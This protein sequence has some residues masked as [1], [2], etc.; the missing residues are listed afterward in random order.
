MT[1]DLI[2]QLWIVRVGEVKSFGVH[3]QLLNGKV[4][5]QNATIIYTVCLHHLSSSSSS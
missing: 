2:L 5:V 3:V 1:V 4:R